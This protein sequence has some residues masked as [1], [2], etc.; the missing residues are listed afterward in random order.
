MPD[1]DLTHLEL[2]LGA[3]KDHPAYHSIYH[4]VVSEGF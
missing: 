3:R 4:G 1:T 2:G